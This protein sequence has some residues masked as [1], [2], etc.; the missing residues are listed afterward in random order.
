VILFLNVPTFFGRTDFVV[1]TLSR[2]ACLGHAFVSIKR[3]LANECVYV[4]TANTPQWIPRSSIGHYEHR[5]KP[6]QLHV[7]GLRRRV[8]SNEA[9]LNIYI[10]IYFFLSSSK[11]SIINALFFMFVNTFWLRH[12]CTYIPIENRIQ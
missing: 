4:Y 1:N 2:A 5:Y 8:Y 10:Y 11:M 12:A 9:D 3:R 6:C 7:V